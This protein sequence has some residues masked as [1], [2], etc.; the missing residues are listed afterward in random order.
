MR[1]RRGNA[2]H[3]LVVALLV[4]ACVQVGTVKPN[5]PAAAFKL[6][7]HEQ[8][9]RA[10]L[11]QLGIPGDRM[12]IIVGDLYT[13]VGNRGSDQYQF[14]SFRHFDNSPDPATVCQR[15][16]EAWTYFYTFIRL[17]VR[18]ANP[19]QWDQIDEGRAADAL[20]AFGALTHSLQDFYA[21]SNWLETH[22]AL[23]QSPATADRLF[24]PPCNSTGW[25]VD[26]QT[27]YFSLIHGIDGCPG[28]TPPTGFKY[29]HE[30]L[31]KD[32]SESPRLWWRV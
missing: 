18:P 10:S 4:V 14:T 29:C 28:T 13:G 12:N 2:P 23:G 16:N 20:S 31:N 6:P 30:A 21:H 9:V 22:I 19:P 8:I 25:P 26:V 17:N 32:D 7:Q 15:A 3:A 27:G 5:S 11:A 1:V 24:P